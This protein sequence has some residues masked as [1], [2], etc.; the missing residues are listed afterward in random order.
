MLTQE[1]VTELCICNRQDLIDKIQSYWSKIS[2]GNKYS[3]Y[4]S[5]HGIPSSLSDEDF[6]NYW[7]KITYTDNWQRIEVKPAYQNI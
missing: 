7:V 1:Q 5:T 3:V 4:W 6:I 2:K